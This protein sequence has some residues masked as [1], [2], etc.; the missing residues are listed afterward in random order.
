MKGEEI[1][2]I[3]YSINIQGAFGQISGV[4]DFLKNIVLLGCNH[5]VTYNKKYIT[6]LV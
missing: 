1:Y 4:A 5:K 2:L 3:C 6:L